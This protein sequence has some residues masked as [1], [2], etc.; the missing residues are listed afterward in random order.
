MK[1]F[2][3]VAA[4]V[5]LGILVGTGNAL[6]VNYPALPPAG[7]PVAGESLLQDSGFNNYVDWIV[8]YV[9][10]EEDDYAD[11]LSSEIGPEVIGNYL[12]LFQLEHPTEYGSD[13][14]VDEFFLT[15][16]PTGTILS[17]GWFDDLDLDD[18]EDGV[19]HNKDTFSVLT[20]EHEE[21]GELEDV[22]WS[23]I[24]GSS[25]GWQFENLGE[26]DHG[27]ARGNESTTM[28]F[29]SSMYP[30]YVTGRSRYTFDENEPTYGPIPGP[31]PEPTSM[32]LMG[33]G[34]LGAFGAK[35]RRKK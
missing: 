17:H 11:I 23:G 31:A 1:K 32:A 9:E 34:L 14:A 10:D 2:L 27:V 4:L 13:I 24:V 22:Y 25:L 35:L 19:G 8:H 26:D 18:L 28:W 5:G 21:E 33:I 20:G 6:A 29:I 3:V 16:I 7:Y 15:N 12:Y 30:T